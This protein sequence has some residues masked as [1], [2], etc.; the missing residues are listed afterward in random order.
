[1]QIDD[2]EFEEEKTQVSL[3]DLLTRIADEIRAGEAVVVPM[4][5]LKE[6]KLTLPLGEPIETGIE[7]NLR[8]NF[9]HLHLSLAW[10]KPKS[11][12]G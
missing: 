9:I 3:A 4:P 5:S 2:F 11:E 10:R 6:G 12:E 8:K 1:M 7:V